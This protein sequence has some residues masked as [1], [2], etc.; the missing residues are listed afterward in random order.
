[1]AL[2][3]GRDGD[4]VGWEAG[5]GRIVGWQRGE[6][7]RVLSPAV[8]LLRVGHRQCSSPSPIGRAGCREPGKPC[9][10][11]RAPTEKDPVGAHTSL[12]ASCTWEGLA[13]KGRHYHGGG[14]PPGVA[15]ATPRVV[16]PSTSPGGFQRSRRVL[17][18]PVWMSPVGRGSAVPCWPT[19]CRPWPQA[20]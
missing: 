13:G 10:G 5:D 18:W 11:G 17:W 16:G 8:L 20:R 12:A 7:R 14:A 15:A 6:G 19:H 4:D 9:L 2:P 3:A 1:M